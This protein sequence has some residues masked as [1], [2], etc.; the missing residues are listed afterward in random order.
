MRNL[1]GGGTLPPLTIEERAKLHEYVEIRFGVLSLEHLMWKLEQFAG[2]QIVYQFDGK[3][4][5]STPVSMSHLLPE[6]G[7]R[8]QFHGFLD[9]GLLDVT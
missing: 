6:G 2:G 4:I 8:A 1:D 3:N 9:N 7:I 5:R